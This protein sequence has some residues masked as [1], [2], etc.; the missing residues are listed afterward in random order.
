VPEFR[1][2][3]DDLRSD[4]RSPTKYKA[5]IEALMS[6][7]T[8]FVPNLV[9]EKAASFYNAAKRRGRKLRTRKWVDPKDNTAGLVMW[10]EPEVETPTS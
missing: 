10:F 2:V 6:G 3:K 4:V 5:E 9:Q 8:I 1:V 7:K